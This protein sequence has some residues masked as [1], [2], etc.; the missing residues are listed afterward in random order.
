MVLT[1]GAA[2]VQIAVLVCLGGQEHFT[3]HQATHFPRTFALQGWAG[4]R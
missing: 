4:R 3:S 1:A 2:D